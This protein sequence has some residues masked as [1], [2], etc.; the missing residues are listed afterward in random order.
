MANYKQIYAIKRQN[1]NQIKKLVPNIQQTSGIYFFYRVDENGIKHGYVGKAETN[2]LERLASH[3]SGYKSHIDRSIKAH[4]L[5]DEEKYPYGY[6]IV[7]LKYCHPQ[8]C[9]ELERTYIKIYADKGYQL[10]NTETGGTKGKTLM[11]ERKEPKSYR[12]GLKQGRTNLARELKHIADLHLNISVKKGKENNSVSIKQ[13]N[14]FIELLKSP[15][16]EEK[17]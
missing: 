6:K 7:I 17:G 3:L 13:Y 15:N 11:N 1:E 12:D 5:Y 4:H 16:N 9:D 14:K 2:I 10:K 8:E